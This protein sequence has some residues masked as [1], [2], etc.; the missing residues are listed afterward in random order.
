MQSSNK[1]IAA[2]DCPKPGPMTIQLNWSKLANE[3]AERTIISGCKI[4]TLGASCARNTAYTRPAP[5]NNAARDANKTAP[6][7]PAS[8]PT[9]ATLPKLP[10]CASAARGGKADKKTLRVSLCLSDGIKFELL[11][12]MIESF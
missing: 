11:L 10:L 3:A 2:I 6:T 9:I 1:R 7:I 12:A 4:S 8:P 5:H